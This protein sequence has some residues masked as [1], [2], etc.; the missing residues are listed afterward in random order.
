MC[1]V[2]TRLPRTRLGLTGVSPA[3]GHKEDE[4]TGALFVCGE[5]GRAGT[6]Q[7]GEGSGALINVHLMGGNE[8]EGAGL[9]SAAPSGGTRGK[10]HKPQ[11]T[12]L[13]LNTRKNFLTATVVEH[14]NRLP[15]EV[16][17]SPPL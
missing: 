14:C 1:S 5:A 7:P 15:T 10:G 3:K 12:K 6:V 16:V 9:S 8:E 17:A 13:K 2:Q 4:G 11:N